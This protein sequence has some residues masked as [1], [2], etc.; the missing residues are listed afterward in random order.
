MDNKPDMVNHPNH[1]ANNRMR[2]IIGAECIEFTRHFSF[3]V[4]NAFKYVW[5]CRD[6][7][8]TMQDLDKA[9]F[10]LNDHIGNINYLESYCNDEEIRELAD[11]MWEFDTDGV[12]DFEMKQIEVL[13]KLIYSPKEALVLLD[14][15]K[16]MIR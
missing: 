6:K 5:R 4:G 14:E 9:S 13:R 8:T 3:D 11:G 16:G 10:Y 1:Y 12:S 2:Q 7:G 15:L